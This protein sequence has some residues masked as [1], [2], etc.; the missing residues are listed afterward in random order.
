MFHTLREVWTVQ[1]EKREKGKMLVVDIIKQEFE[2]VLANPADFVNFE[3]Y[4][5]C[6]RHHYDLVQLMQSTFEGKRQ[7]ARRQF[8]SQHEANRQQQYLQQQQQVHQQQRMHHVEPMPS[9]RGTAPGM[10]GGAGQ[11]LYGQHHQHAGAP[12]RGMRMG[13]QLQ[14]QAERMSQPHQYGMQ[15][16]G[17]MG[18]HGGFGGGMMPEGD[19]LIRGLGGGF[20]QRNNPAL[21]SPPSMLDSVGPQGGAHVMHRDG[22]LSEPQVMHGVNRMPMD[23]GAGGAAG[24]GHGMGHAWQHAAHPTLLHGGYNS[25]DLPS[26]MMPV[27]SSFGLRAGEM[28]RQH[29][30]ADHN[31]GRMPL[32][33][34]HVYPYCTLLYL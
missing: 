30:P 9:I 28:P 13:G 4:L 21:M 20:E 1:V 7:K 18:S 25:H 8:A 16:S 27:G 31:L 34:V 6:K 3:S 11:M 15:H 23:R 2:M 19:N 26:D 33:G 5:G 22:R 29:N 12:G 10:A 17:M 14:G 32:A 24:S